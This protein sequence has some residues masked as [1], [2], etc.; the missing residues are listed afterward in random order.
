MSM[1]IFT[2]FEV[3]G[4][5]MCKNKRIYV[6]GESAGIQQ[7]KNKHFLEEGNRI[8]EKTFYDLLRE[9]WL[10]SSDLVIKLV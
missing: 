1:T 7:N 2:Y 6:G 10:E 8:L 4:G 3:S 5:F 9:H